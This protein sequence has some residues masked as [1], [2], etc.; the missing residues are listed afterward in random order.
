MVRLQR[1]GL[2]REVVPA[3]FFLVLLRPGSRERAIDPQ[4]GRHRHTEDREDSVNCSIPH[5]YDSATG[6]TGP[7]RWPRGAPTQR[8]ARFE[9]PR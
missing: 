7:G 6:L 9:P 8:R 3:A 1:Y 2:A 4:S 5:A